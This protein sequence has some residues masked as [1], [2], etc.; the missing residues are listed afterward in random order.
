MSEAW[1]Y[2]S[3]EVRTSALD[4][5]LVLQRHKAGVRQVISE[6]ESG[7]ATLEQIV[8]AADADGEQ[9]DVTIRPDEAVGLWVLSGPDKAHCIKTA[10]YVGTGT[11][12]TS[13]CGM[14]MWVVDPEPK[15]QYLEA[16]LCQRCVKFAPEGER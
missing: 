15:G 5:R 2:A 14:G 6:W 7:M 3:Y 1:R 12:G 11:E 13:Y 16:V 10:R 9:R 8:A 4:D